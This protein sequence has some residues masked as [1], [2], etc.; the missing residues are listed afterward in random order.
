LLPLLEPISAPTLST[1]WESVGV[2]GG[3]DEFVV[4]VKKDE[5][6]VWVDVVCVV[7]TV[8]LVVGDVE[9]DVVDAA[10]V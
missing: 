2:G 1:P 4:V 7:G 8:K 5:L 9:E 3:L 6:E 10:G